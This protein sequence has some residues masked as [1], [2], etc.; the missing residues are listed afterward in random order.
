MKIQISQNLMILYL[1][2]L[3]YGGTVERRL[4]ELIGG[5]GCSENRYFRIIELMYIY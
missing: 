1:L 5:R 3:I 2:S 4:S